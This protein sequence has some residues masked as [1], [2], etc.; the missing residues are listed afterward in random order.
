M[1]AAAARHGLTGSAWQAVGLLGFLARFAV[2][3]TLPAL[4]YALLASLVDAALRKRP[5]EPGLLLRLAGHALPGVALSLYLWRW[6]QR[7][8]AITA[9]A[10]ALVAVALGLGRGVGSLRGR[11]PGI[12]RFLPLLALGALLLLGGLAQLLS[13]TGTGMRYRALGSSAAIIGAACSAAGLELL[14]MSAAT[15]LKVTGAFVAALALSFIPASLS[16][17]SAAAALSAVGR[18][19]TS[20]GYSEKQERKPGAV[21][22]VPDATRL[23]LTAT[24]LPA[25]APAAL[26]QYNFLLITTEAT[27]FD[28]TSLAGV[29]GHDNTPRLLE[30]AKKQDAF[31]FTR[32][33][34][35]SN[36]TLA[37]MSSLLSLAY[38]AE[39]ELTTW[40]VFW[41]GQ[42]APQAVTLAELFGQAGFSTFRVSHDFLG[43]FSK[44]M[45][46]FEQGFGSNR[47]E[48][49]DGLGSQGKT[50]DSRIADGALAELTQLKAS[51]KPFFGWVFFGGPHAPY[52]V[53]YPDAPSAKPVDRYQQE[54]RFMDEQLGR[55]LR[56]LEQL[57][58]DKSTIVVF[59]ADHGEEL[60]EHGGAGHHTLF[61]ECV[62]VPLVV[63]VPGM[64]GKRIE[65]PISTLNTLQWLTSQHAEPLRVATQQTLSQQV[66]PLLTALDGA[67]LVETLG[68]DMT[69]SAFIRGQS[70][71]ICDIPS[72]WCDVYD[73]SQD[74]GEKRP[75]PSSSPQAASW[76]QTF[77]RYMD[78]RSKLGRFKTDP[79]R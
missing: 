22:A 51:G 31:V 38:P 3:A 17:R 32:A 72:A 75:L 57:G 37:S 64:T 2:G 49:D 15:G 9:V 50:L 33:Y 79:E 24:G 1:N 30:W 63:H 7:A 54:V 27:R 47:L 76:R 55:V 69:V 4:G 58:L 14:R 61:E 16:G 68:H 66:G 65:A 71:A 53:H 52:E 39:T 40:R 12:W 29:A 21:A 13:V 10:L 73:L 77:E 60:Y 26:A 28:Q 67:V 74:P 44:A 43:A 20:S 35:P 46:G 11:L 45:L 8:D 5:T 18:A 6:L 48:G 59:A 78:V 70:K 41:R 23:L 25:L 56:G 36:G 42:L 19:Q 62:H 34:S